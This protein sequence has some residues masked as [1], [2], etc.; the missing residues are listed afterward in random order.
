[1][2]EGKSIGLGDLEE[3]NIEVLSG[4]LLFLELDQILVGW[5]S[6]VFAKE[7]QLKIIHLEKKGLLLQIEELDVFGVNSMVAS[8]RCRHL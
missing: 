2:Q 8:L 3:F 7:I 5:V 4:D 1:M 6:V